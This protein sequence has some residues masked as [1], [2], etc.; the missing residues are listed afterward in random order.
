VSGVTGELWMEM[1]RMSDAEKGSWEAV[2]VKLEDVVVV[3]VVEVC[4]GVGC[5]CMFASVRV[6]NS[7]LGEE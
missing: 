6:L 3:V 7:Y 5:Y 2:N 1:S 4:F